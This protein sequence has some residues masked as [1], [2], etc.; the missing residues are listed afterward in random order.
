MLIAH[1][2]DTHLGA[3][4][5]GLDEREDD[6]YNALSN[7]I[8]IIIKDHIDIVIHSGDIFDTPRP[9]GTAIIKLIKELKKLE[10]HDI[11]FFFILG[12]HDISRVRSTPIPFIYREVK[13]ATYISNKEVNNT[14]NI[15]SISITGYNKHRH[16]E[17][18]DLREKLKSIRSDSKKRILV[19]HQALQE[20]H[21]YAG[22]ISHLDLPNNFDYY[23]MGHLHNRYSKH[24]EGFKGPLC[25]PGSTE[26]T[27][28]ASTEDLE[29]GFY[30]IDLSGDEAKPNW[31]RIKTRSHMIID[32]DNNYDEEDIIKRLIDKPILKVRFKDIDMARARSILRTLESH[33]LHIIP[34][35]LEY[36]YHDTQTSDKH[37]SLDEEM[38]IISKDILNSEEKAR[39]AILELL[40]SLLEDDKNALDLLWHAYTSKRFG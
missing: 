26:I 10:E 14:V 16:N 20:A 21:P 9:T 7:T 4:P 24:F 5:Y 1:I 37:H 36:S 25:Y 29:K 28:F 17:I 2:S 19:L 27:K 39:F 32:I 40:P 6:F 8:D 23:A 13:L 15:G 12:E 18:H 35:Y 11:K 31:I 38:L 22:E 30:I 3:I 33:A 34:E